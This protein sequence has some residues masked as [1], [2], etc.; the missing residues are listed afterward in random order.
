MK[1][2]AFITI[3]NCRIDVRA[4]TPQAAWNKLQSIPH[5]KRQLTRAYF[6][7]DPDGFSSVNKPYEYIPE[8]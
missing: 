4:A 7:Y 3:D 8:G 2:Y 6:C 1:T 5:L